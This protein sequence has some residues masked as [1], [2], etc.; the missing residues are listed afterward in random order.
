MLDMGFGVQLDKIAKYLPEVRQ[1]L[2]FSA[3]IPLSM[4][5]LTKK[6]LNNPERISIGSSTK[7]VLKIKQEILHTTANEKFS[8]LMKQLD[9]RAG[10]IIIFVRTKRGADRLSRELNKL[11]H[12]TNAIHGDLP[13]KRR[14]QVIHAFRMNKSRILVATDVA[15]RGLDIP[16]VL[17]VINYDLPECPEDYIHRIGRTGRAGMDGNALCLVS[18][19]DRDKWKAVVRLMDPQAKSNAPHISRPTRP[20]RSKG[21]RHKQARSRAKVQYNPPGVSV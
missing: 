13:Q 7:P 5:R 9:E 11:G 21:R 14:G 16:H 15:A 10:A 1:T 2:M 6:Y 12:N 17:H 19:Q 4:D 18:P 20:F 8:L 3:T